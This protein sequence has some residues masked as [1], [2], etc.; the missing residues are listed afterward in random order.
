M[1]GEWKVL[2]DKFDFDDSTFKEEGKSSIKNDHELEQNQFFL[3]RRCG[4]KHTARYPFAERYG[5]NY[6][7]SKLTG[8]CDGPLLRV[9]I[10]FPPARRRI[11]RYSC[12]NSR[13]FLYVWI[14]SCILV[15]SAS[16]SR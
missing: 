9:T 7:H 12:F 13:L 10:H 5:H 3:H 6:G 2:A 16:N 8:T 14:Y 4:L 11:Y 1:S 15:L